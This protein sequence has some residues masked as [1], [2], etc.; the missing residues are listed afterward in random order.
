M[1]TPNCN[2]AY[3]TH[4]NYEARYNTT[5]THE[6]NKT[7]STADYVGDICTR[8][9]NWTKRP[10]NHVWSKLDCASY[11]TLLC[12]KCGEVKSLAMQRD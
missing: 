11:W 3:G 4:C 7:T 10:C 2:K 6:D 1:T 8:C 12:Q 5:E 9:G